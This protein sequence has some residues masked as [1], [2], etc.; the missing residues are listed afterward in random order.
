MHGQ[1]RQHGHAG[2][3]QEISDSKRLRKRVAGRVRKRNQIDGVLSQ[4]DEKHSRG[5]A[6]NRRGT[7]WESPGY[8]GGIKRVAG[9]G[10]QDRE[11]RAGQRVSQKRRNR[12]RHARDP[13]LA[14]AWP[15]EAQTRRKNR[16][17]S[18]EAR[19]AR[20][21]DGLESLAHLARPPPLLRAQARLLK[22]RGLPALP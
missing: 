11:R 10:P 17:R 15:D 5:D 21:L 3:V 1:T 20:A 7:W 18:D 16:A 13:P 2:L 4:Q 9:C 8:D 19:A 22:L 14:A 6:R 12:G